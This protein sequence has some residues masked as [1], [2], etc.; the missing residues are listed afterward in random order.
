MSAAGAIL[1]I[2]EIERGAVTR[3]ARE[4]LGL[5]L[6]LKAQ[7]GYAVNAAVFAPKGGAVA[8]ELIALGAERVYCVEH[9]GLVGYHSEAWTS[10]AAQLCEEASP[11]LVLTGHNAVGADL[12]PR[13]AF[14]MQGSV[15][16]GCVDISWRDGACHFTR[17]CYGGNVRETL[18]FTPGL[19]VATV[20][21]GCSPASVPEAA[22]RGEVRRFQPVL[23]QALKRMRVVA[24]RADAAEGLRLEDAAVIVAGGRGLNGPDGFRA[25]ETLADVLGGAVGASRVPCDLGWCPR[26]WQ[27]GLTGRTVQPALYIAVGISGAGHHMAGC[28]NAKTIVAVNTDANA[29]IYRDA[30][31]GIVAD[32]QQFVPAFIDEV[33]KLKR[34]PSEAR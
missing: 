8:E 16:T 18:S 23:D 14:R 4:L 1:V 24:R 10:A 20:R 33:R 29:A 9:P 5:A 17:P 27:I 28:G 3:L 21:A 25:L 31:F 12:A 13:L 34:A 2:S 32:H 19:C 11:K 7:A 22:R 30:R 6:G 15:A 26:T